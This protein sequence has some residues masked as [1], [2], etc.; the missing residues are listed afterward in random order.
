[1]DRTRYL[2]W[3]VD[4]LTPYTYTSYHGNHGPWIVGSIPPDP[5]IMAQN[6]GVFH[7]LSAVT[8]AQ[9]TD[10]TSQTLLFGEKAH[11]L[12]DEEAARWMYDWISSYLPDTSFQT[13][14]GI[15]PHRRFAGSPFAFDA[16]VISTSSFHPGGAHFA[17]LDGSVR[18]LKD[19]IDTWP[20][21]PQTGDTGAYWDDA[22]VCA[23]LR[24]GT[25]FG[26]YQALS[27]RA[28]GEVLTADAY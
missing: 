15:N 16:T 24:P 23:R 4:G 19:S 20:V 12:L 18:F 11:G 3:G 26:V 8:P 10:G 17:F 25:R 6:L 27:T 5:R 1:V 28:G 21:D 14:Y 22:C 7:E 13:W 2:D 9:V